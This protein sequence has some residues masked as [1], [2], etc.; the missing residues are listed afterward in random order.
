MLCSKCGKEIPENSQFCNI[1]GTK[2]EQPKPVNTDTA[3][4]RN[5]EKK[6]SS[7]LIRIAIWII[8]V[9]FLA[10]SIS[11]MSIPEMI[12]AIERG[13]PL[14]NH[15]L[16][17]LENALKNQES[18]ITI[19]KV[20]WDTKVCPWS[21]MGSFL[22]DYLAGNPE[23]YYI[24]TKNTKITHTETAEDSFYTLNMVYFDDL[25]SDRA[26][27]RL[28]NAADRMLQSMPS[29]ISDWEKALYI[30]DALIRHVT[31]ESGDRDQ[32]AYG[33]LVDGKAVCM[34]YSMAY[35]YLLTK[36]GVECDTVIGYADSLS[37]A[38]DSPVITVDLH[39]W[40]VVTFTE[41]GVKRSYY[42]DTTWDDPDKKDTYGTDYVRHRWFCA[43]QEDLD[44]E[45]RSTLQE[46]Y[47]LSQ[48]N[49]D[50]DAMNYYVY[51]NAV[52]DS[53][54]LDEVIQIMQTQYLQGSNFLSLRMADLDTYYDLKFAMEHGGD[55][56][57]LGEA[58][59]IH[60]YAYRFSYNYSGDG[61]LCFDIF[62]NYPGQ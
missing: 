1:C 51:T 28:E 25:T 45:G 5:A 16:Y 40:S 37:A 53:Y 3:A 14:W 31:Y 8:G 60:S 48:W 39:A 57:K 17:D 59:G 2:V 10:G 38:I 50:D 24:D 4:S 13:E 15:G 27:E 43:T 34:G 6:K 9:V 22:R 52:I 11:G 32:T 47:D 21:Q 54:D 33:A 35:E 58:L 36:A 41:N 55:I 30:H 20:N 56:Q 18:V 49:L 44:K 46:G 62:L 29:H 26:A 12:G 7:P 42:V 23:L 19:H 61:L